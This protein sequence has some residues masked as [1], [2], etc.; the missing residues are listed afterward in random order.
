[1][2]KNIFLVTLHC[3]VLLEEKA[4]GLNYHRV[5]WVL[6]GTVKWKKLEW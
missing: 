3:P 1:M 2:G 6:Y 5:C 4:H